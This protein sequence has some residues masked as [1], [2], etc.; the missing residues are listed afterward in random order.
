MA[1]VTCSPDLPARRQ[2]V[3]TSALPFALPIAPGGSAQALP[4]PPSR[5]SSVKSVSYVHGG[6]QAI[7]C[8][9]GRP[10]PRRKEDLLCMIQ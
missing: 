8:E 3:I 6:H 10:T 7:R 5:D 1:G 4:W 9:W 2:F